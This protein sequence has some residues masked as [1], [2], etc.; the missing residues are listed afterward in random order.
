MVARTVSIAIEAKVAGA[1]AGL[2]SLSKAASGAVTELEKSAKKRQAL[3]E[4]GDTAGKAGLAAA[5]GLGAIVVASS[6]FEK[7]MSG[8]KAAT[9]GTAQELDRLRDAAI[10][11]GADTAFS[12]SEAAD[13]IEQLAKAG[14]STGDILAGGLTGALDLA[15]A[16]QIGVGE[17]AE[18]AAKAMTQFGLSGDQVP[19]VADLLAAAAGK[20]SG[21]VGDFGMALN[22]SGLVADQVG[23]SIE[24]TTGALA[25]FASAG[26]LG[27]DAGTSFKTMLGALTPNSAAAASEMQRLGISAYDAQGNFVG[28]A[29]FAGQ[30]Q[31]S[32]STLSAEQ[33]QA[34]L[35]TIFGS[36][37]VRAASVLYEQGESGVRKWTAAVDDQGFAAET[38]AT[39]L[40]N[41]AG[42]L[43]ALKGSLETALIGSSEGAQG[44]LRSLTQTLT[45]A[46][47]AYNKLPSAAQG[48][49]TGLLGAAALLGGSIWVTSKLATG[50]AN[51][52]NAL[53]ELQGVAPKTGAAL[54]GITT[55][56]T[57][58]TILTTLDTVIDGLE[59]SM[60]DALPSA[61]KLA[62]QLMAI[63]SG[64]TSGLGKEFRDLGE[65]IDFMNSKASAGS[66][67]LS[68]IPNITG[69]IPGWEN[70]GEQVGR[71][72]REFEA[73]D[74]A[75]ASLASSGSF[76]QA[77][78]AFEALA[79]AEGLSTSQREQL[80]AQLPQYESALAA[81]ANEAARVD[82]ATRA[83]AMTGRMAAEA[84]KLRAGALD[85]D[86]AAADRHADASD[87][88]ADKT[89]G[90]KAAL[91]QLNGI[92][93]GRASFRD[94]EASIDGFTSALDEARESGGKFLNAT[95]TGFRIGSEQGRAME[96]ALDG[97]ASSALRVA[98]DMGKVERRRF[99]VR[100]RE[101]LV[102]A[103]RQAG[104]TRAAA[105]SL[106][107][108]L[109]DLDR[110]NAKPDI[111]EEGGER[112]RKSVRETK[113]DVQ[114]LD[115]QKATP[116]IDV[117]AAPALGSINA[118]E[119]ALRNVDGD[120]ATATIRTERITVYSSANAA[121]QRIARA[122]GGPV[123]GPGSK[124]SD[125]VPAM[126]SKGEYVMRAAAVDRYGM[127]FM[128]QVN[129]MRL[130]D[131]GPVGGRAVGGVRVGEA[132][133]DR[134]ERRVREGNED[135]RRGNAETKRIRERTEQLQQTVEANF[136]NDPFEANATL[137]G[138]VASLRADTTRAD[139]F[140]TAARQA[141]RLG[142]DGA[143]LR[144][145]LESGNTAVLEDL[146][147]RGDV[148]SLEAA[149]RQRNRATD[150][151][152]FGAW[153][154][155]ADRGRDGAR[156]RAARA[157][158]R[159][160][161]TTRGLESA[162]ERGARH[163][164]REGVDADR[165]RRARSAS[166]ARLP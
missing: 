43:E 94:F 76:D 78:A 133:V 116:R 18:Y 21:E 3:G 73:L 82:S 19:H 59:R 38:A 113:G 10:Q 124:T 47:N 92:L 145:L 139:E 150:Q 66:D 165:R 97:I 131:G 91:E 105:R 54:R 83:A 161:R 143:V 106:A 28:L 49:V 89:L 42:D 65:S 136:R 142:L 158:E 109:L 148:R 33:R 101:D 112:T 135:R 51:T 67:A 156:A 154:G 60:A 23:V 55:A 39:K 147:S 52:R 86:A 128:H 93:S 126:L 34:A 108:E 36:D 102:S 71:V 12:A 17:A 45:D 110:T 155:G 100:A 56:A 44:P 125:S 120:V 134:V 58:L 46:V 123:F 151:L 149:W 31:G 41:L 117:N 98:E 8:V 13:G 37:A 48:S 63:Q 53:S 159:L 11:A 26:L 132:A 144:A 141:R 79:V 57:G 40:D 87:R 14:V 137:Q 2:N 70:A 61:E 119:N 107:N 95:R 88:A 24:E 99:L 96:A 138:V 164:T 103:A 35:E 5:A 22:Q 25:A 16:G 69:L 4:L 130:A 118:V 104:L 27:S 122:A 129:A 20:A 29:D 80:I 9:G 114:D 72:T 81:A 111:D 32:L 115:R 77:E 140:S 6:R 15:A 166:R 50:I 1:V 160:E 74:G 7:A 62:G 68:W 127:G 157:V 84:A 153:G 30:L 64:Q 146:G 90:F 162:V 121:E 75:L 163:G 152:T 85:E